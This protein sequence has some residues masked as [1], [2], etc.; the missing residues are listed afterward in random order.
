MGRLECGIM[1]ELYDVQRLETLLPSLSVTL[2]LLLRMECKWPFKRRPLLPSLLDPL[3]LAHQ[4]GEKEGESSL[5]TLFGI[6][7]RRRSE[8][9]EG[10]VIIL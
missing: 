4:R 3:F 10:A 1:S 2:P 5:G 8:G 6:Q 7:E 9:V